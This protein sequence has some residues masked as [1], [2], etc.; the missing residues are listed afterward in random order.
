MSAR[1]FKQPIFETVRGRGVNE[2]IT[3]SNERTQITRLWPRFGRLDWI[4]IGFDAVLQTKSQRLLGGLQSLQSS[5]LAD[6]IGPFASLA[7]LGAKLGALFTPSLVDEIFARLK[8]ESLDDFRNKSGL[9]LD[10][11]GVGAAF[12]PN[13]PGAARDFSVSLRF[14]IADGFDVAGRCNRRNCA[15]P[16]SRARRRRSR[17]T[18]SNP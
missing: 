11:V 10:F 4:D 3:P 1:A 17:R 2:R 5:S 6:R 13:D 15:A 18:M 16:S 14:K 9:F 12:D 8:I 7:D